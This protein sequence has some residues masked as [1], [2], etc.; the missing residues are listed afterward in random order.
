MTLSETELREELRLFKYDLLK[1][2]GKA[3][4]LARQAITMCMAQYDD[5][6]GDIDILTERI[7][8]I[9]EKIK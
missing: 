2:I 7:E 9:E 6:E 8:K 3:K 5:A 4:S 1:E